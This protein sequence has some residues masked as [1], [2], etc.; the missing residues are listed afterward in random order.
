MQSQNYEE[1]SAF[2]FGIQ[3]LGVV[4]GLQL[5]GH[6]NI[7]LTNTCSKKDRQTHTH[8]TFLL[9]AFRS[10]L[11]GLSPPLVGGTH[12]YSSSNIL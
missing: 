5:K 6:G 7:S 3:M 9:K 8:R 10:C 12:L 4:R 2:V 11:M 1:K